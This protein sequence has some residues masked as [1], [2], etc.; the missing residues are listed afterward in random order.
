M[1]DQKEKI[2]TCSVCGAQEM[3]EDVQA[4]TEAMQQHMHLAHN[5]DVPLSKI[6]A[7]IKGIGPENVP[8][9][10]PVPTVPMGTPVSAFPGVPIVPPK[11]ISSG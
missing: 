2:A 1:A 4:L 6:A 9:M 5:M 7:E 11:E 3:A 8:D 10:P